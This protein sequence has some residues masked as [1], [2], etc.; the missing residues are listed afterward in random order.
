[1]CILLE[2]HSHGTSSPVSNFQMRFSFLCGVLSNDRLG[3]LAS[4][5]ELHSLS[6]SF[7]E[8]VRLQVEVME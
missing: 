2:N 1:M 6:F 4:R 5:L 3:K 7:P 8:Q